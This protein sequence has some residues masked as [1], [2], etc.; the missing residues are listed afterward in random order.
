MFDGLRRVAYW[1]GLIGGTLFT[2][3]VIGAVNQHAKLL[4]MA[5]VGDGFAD[6]IK[7]VGELLGQALS[8][9]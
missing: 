2:L 8:H 5:A 9:L 3:A 4:S 7:W 6:C 1:V